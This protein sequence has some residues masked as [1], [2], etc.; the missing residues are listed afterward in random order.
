MWAHPLHSGSWA[1]HKAPTLYWYR[2][3]AS[4]K[5]VLG[6]ATESGSLE[7]FTET[8]LPGLLPV[9]PHALDPSFHTKR[10]ARSMGARLRL[11]GVHSCTELLEIRS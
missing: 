4:S 7:A 11:E 3:A 6:K 8:H 9:L 1:A 10:T 2:L 5:D